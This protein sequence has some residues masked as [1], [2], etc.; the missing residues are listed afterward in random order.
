MK[1]VRHRIFD[2][3]VENGG[4]PTVAGCAA[5]FKPLEFVNLP[6]QHEIGHFLHNLVF[7]LFEERR[8]AVEAGH[9]HIPVTAALL[10]HGSHV[11]R[12]PLEKAFRTQ[13]LRMERGVPFPRL[14]GMT[15]AT[16][17]CWGVSLQEPINASNL[18]R[19]L[20]G[21]LL[22]NRPGLQDVPHC[23]KADEEE[24]PAEVFN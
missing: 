6:G 22:H 20:G 19:L 10:L 24:D 17:T 7:N 4:L 16:L 9:V 18:V 3:S 11:S 1:W 15:V 8:M 13:G 12:E 23:Q 2:W 5:D 21:S 14:L